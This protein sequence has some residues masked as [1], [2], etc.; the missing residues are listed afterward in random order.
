MGGFGVGRKKTLG[1]ME[2]L[3]VSK[4]KGRSFGAGVQERGCGVVLGLS[5]QICMLLDVIWLWWC[6]CGS[7]SMGWCCRTWPGEWMWL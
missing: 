1:I 3:A 7:R 6:W 4:G 2:D 5:E